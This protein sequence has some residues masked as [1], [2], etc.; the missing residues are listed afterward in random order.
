LRPRGLG[1]CIVLIGFGTALAPAQQAAPRLAQPAPELG[2]LG[3]FVG[4]F[5]CKGE[6]F[7]T[8]L[9]GPH[10]VERTIV[11]K[12]DLD[13][14]WLFMRFEDKDTDANPMPVRGNWQLA[15]DARVKTFVALWTDNLGRWFPQVSTGWDRDAI[16]FTGEFSLNGQKGVVRDTF[17]KTSERSMTM[18]VEIQ[19]DGAWMRFLEFSCDK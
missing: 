15:Y 3:F 12:M 10:P 6:A 13:G 18:T 5:A 16:A 19:R 2:Q 1:L 14:F 17:S 4:A 8:P 9:G 11:G 7:R